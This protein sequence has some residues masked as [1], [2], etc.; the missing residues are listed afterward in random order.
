MSLTLT[1][2]GSSDIQPLRLSKGVLPI[3]RN[4]QPFASYPRTLSGRLSRRHARIFFEG[5]QYFISDLGSRNG[6]LVSGQRVG[7]EPRTL[8][9]GDEID[10]GGNL[11]FAV[12]IEPSAEGD[13]PNSQSVE[14]VL[15]PKNPDSGLLRV[16]IEQFPVLIGKASPPFSVYENS[17]PEELA[18]LSRRHAHFYTRDGQVFLEDLG[19]T[20]GSYVDSERLD[21]EP[22]Q[23]NGGELISFG[24]DFFEY[25]LTLLQPT[26]DETDETRVVDVDRTRILPRRA[27]PTK[28]LPAE[29]SSTAAAPEV[30]SSAP[31]SSDEGSSKVDSAVEDAL[32]ADNPK[33]VFVSSATSF[34]EI[35]C[36]DDSENNK[37]RA[38]ID[39]D[40]GGGQADVA[41]AP[42]RG[43][44]AQ[45][46]RRRLSLRVGGLVLLAGLV[47][48]VV[49]LLPLG[50]EAELRTLI[51]AGKLAEAAR[52]GDKWLKDPTVAATI[53][54]LASEALMTQLVPVWL[55]QVEAGDLE[56]AASSVAKSQDMAVNNT[57]G[58]QMLRLLSWVGDL[59]AFVASHGGT[60]I[61]I[62]MYRD[63]PVIRDI[64]ARWE[65]DEAGN[66][67]TLEEIAGYVPEFAAVSRDAHSKLRTLHA[68]EALNVAAIDELS[69]SLRQGLR[70][71]VRENAADRDRTF[72][73]LADEIGNFRTK[74]PRVR[75]A[76]QL[77][78]DLLDF[79]R[80]LE[81][82]DR[83]E[84]AGMI[85]QLENAQPRTQPF[86][87]HYRWLYESV[88]PSPALLSG[89]RDALTAWRSGRA[90]EAIDML[91]GLDGRSWQALIQDTLEHFLLVA[92]RYDELTASKTAPG[93]SDRLIAFHAL[94]EDDTDDYFRGALAKDFNAASDAVVAQAEKRFAAARTGWRSFQDAGG[95]DGGIRIQPQV[96]EVFREQA[97]RL[98]KAWQYADDG[99]SLY[100]T[101]SMPPPEPA[102]SLHAEIR[103]EIKRQR[104]WLK[105]LELVMGP[106]LTRSK[107]ELLPVITEDGETE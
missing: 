67:R 38:G 24:G 59:E 53:E 11:K 45:R 49:Y 81:L 37:A 31:T 86:I 90:N 22:R 12:S 16:V 55:A 1:A 91:Q 44:Q 104:G 39:S 58:Q 71:T 43:A 63:E 78:S 47:A 28:A 2:I 70:R 36:S 64:I 54:P 8:T 101:I 73:S 21:A 65:S 107:I 5:G 23:L 17:F 14:I 72:K 66:R 96:T 69:D 97:G 79:R 20:N 105:D 62:Q 30:G 61:G 19:S 10:L 76:D 42:D 26:D 40:S 57:Q 98:S 48:L 68:F 51:D 82:I 106:T 99:V 15:E 88:L 3:G 75:G 41:P 18:F 34:L 29:G 103:L 25:R 60:D 7:D 13:G 95:I 33:T 94:L 89:Y 35:F 74:Y 92:I 27:S 83:Q 9:T 4:D 50:K 6:T 52:T 102:R 93:Y 77:D 32:P 46:A 87:Q 100:K 80:L 85:T 84:L 56:A